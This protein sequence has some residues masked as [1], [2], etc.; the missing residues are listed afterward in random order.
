MR[1]GSDQNGHAAGRALIDIFASVG[2]AHFVVSWTNSAGSPRRPRTLRKT[3]Q[4]HGC[5]LPTTPRNEDWLDAVFIENISLAEITRI[6]PALLD[7][8]IANRLNLIVRPYGDG[9][10][11]I[12]LDDLKADQLPKLAP[13]VFLTLETSPENFQAWLALPGTDDRDFARRVRK[14]AGADPTASGATR[15]AGSFNFKDK[16]AP[17]F[18]R[19]AISDAHAG[20]VTTAAELDRL[21]L[22][23][24][25]EP[26]PERPISPARSR[27]G[28]GRRKWP[29]YERCLD[30]APPSQS[31]KGQPRHSIADFTWCMIAAD[32]GWPVEEI[33]RRL[34]EESTKARENGPVYALKTAT[35][36]AEAAARNAERRQQQPN[37]HRIS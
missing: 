12:Q 33:A 20:R 31:N 13:A 17:N 37:R 23:A 14:G 6:M 29:N 35:R 7:A 21:G 18:P 27:P 15:V 36:A 30:G 1:D 26:V 16:Y 28:P 5:A 3:L 4:S 9:I 34:M 11:F 2:A 24:A 25:P 19:V 32:W 10:S 8:A 22:V